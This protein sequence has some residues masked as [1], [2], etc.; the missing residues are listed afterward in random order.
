MNL[1]AYGELRRAE[2]LRELFGCLPP[3]EPAVVR[4]HVRR[5]DPESGYF[6]AWPAMGATVVGLLT[7]FLV[8][9]SRIRVEEEA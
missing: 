5:P 4:D 6:T 3:A 7:N 9:R 8:A 1:F 2:V